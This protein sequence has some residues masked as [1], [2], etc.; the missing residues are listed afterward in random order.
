MCGGRR[1]VAHAS[2]SGF[3]R[4]RP[5]WLG[6]G[7]GYVETCGSGKDEVRDCFRPVATQGRGHVGV[8]RQSG[9]WIFII[10][11][12]L[13]LVTRTNWQNPVDQLDPWGEATHSLRTVSWRNA[14][15]FWRT[16]AAFI[17]FPPSLSPLLFIVCC[18]VGCYVHFC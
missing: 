1:T 10:K 2:V 18:Q 13:A 16:T 12:S 14:A 17:H 5:P 3:T 6:G 15:R 7:G 9:Q 8:P 4:R 11:K